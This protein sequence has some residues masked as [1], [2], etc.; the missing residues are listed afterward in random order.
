MN[1]ILAKRYAFCDFSKIVGFPNPVPSRDE[2]ERSIPRFQGEEWEV[3]A[4]HLLDFHDFIHRLEIVH[5][6]VQIK[7][8]GF[9]LE[10]I[11]RDWYRSLPVASIISLA[12]FHAAFH[13]FCQDIFSADLLY[14]ECCHDF[15]LLNKDPNI[16]EDFV[17]VEDISYCDRG[18]VDPH[19]DNH[20]FDIVL[21]ANIK[22]GCHEDQ[23][24][25]FE[26]FKD[27][28]QMDRSAGDSIESAVDVEGSIQFPDL[29]IK[30]SCSNHE[31]RDC[32]G[33]YNL[34]LEHQKNSP[35]PYEYVVSNYDE[36][37][38]DIFPNLFQEPIADT[39]IQRYSSLSL[40]SYLYAPTFDQYSDKEEDLKRYGEG[41]QKV[42]DQQSSLHFSP[43]K[44]EQSTF[45]IEIREGSQQQHFSLQSEQKLEEVFLYYFIDPI[46][47]FLESLSSIK[48]KIFLSDE[49]W[50]YH[51]FRTHLCWLRILLFLGSRSRILSA[52]KF[53][54][55]LHWK[56][57]FT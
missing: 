32:R 44:V 47:D 35:S 39:F 6:D 30:G 55:W 25:S 52:N 13:L 26:N 27:D 34:Q 41:E 53:L 51:F 37:Q 2:W 42:S 21:N 9:S 31:E 54:T 28:E 38:G 14:P 48:I 57:E 29:Q 17:A 40:G 3:P 5:E 50:F 18:I 11:S 20:G 36:E 8:F 33:L 46:A 1:K 56:H 16:H 45:S 7:L 12:D 49:D 10:G 43:T 4:E 22:D 24:I 19:Y 23:I 15:N